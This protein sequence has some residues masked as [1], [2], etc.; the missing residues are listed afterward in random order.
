MSTLMLSSWYSLLPSQGQGPFQFAL[1]C[2]ATN[3]LQNPVGHCIDQRGGPPMLKP[4]RE[5]AFRPK[6]EL[7]GDHFDQRAQGLIRLPKAFDLLNRVKNGGVVP[8]VEESSDPGCALSHNVLLPDTW[9][10]VG[11]NKR[12]PGS[13]GRVLSRDDPRP[14]LRFAPVTVA[15]FQFVAPCC[16][17]FL[18]RRQDGSGSV[19]PQSSARR[20]HCGRTLRPHGADQV[21]PAFQPLAEF[22]RPGVI[23]APELIH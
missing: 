15:R 18:S 19:H 7:G 17:S 8:T 14:W 3:L 6:T 11:S 2:E 23:R 4:L 9:K 10:R 12:E 20:I 16:A 5:T 1:S 21:E 22:P 13:Q